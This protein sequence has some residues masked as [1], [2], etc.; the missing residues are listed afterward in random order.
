MTSWIEAS[1]RELRLALRT[2]EDGSE[3]SLVTASV[4][5]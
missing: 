1:F 5:E 2:C 3:P 4:R